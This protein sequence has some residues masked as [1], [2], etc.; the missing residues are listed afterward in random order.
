[1]ASFDKKQM[2]IYLKYG[3]KLRHRSFTQGEY[4]CKGSRRAIA[5]EDG[6]ETSNVDFWSIR[7][8]EA[9]AKDWSLI[10]ESKHGIMQYAKLPDTKEIGQF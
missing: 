10:L 2:P 1:M 3:Y 8:D 7:T 6:N 4:I 9:W 5:F